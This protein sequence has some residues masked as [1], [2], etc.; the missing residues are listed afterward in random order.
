MGRIGLSSPIKHWIFLALPFAPS[1]TLTNYLIGIA[2]PRRDHL[3][4]VVY[5]GAD[6]DQ[7]GITEYAF[8][9]LY[10]TCE[11]HSPAMFGDRLLL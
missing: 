2:T 4:R 8:D 5:P 6:L 7:G 10:L 3:G 1:I 9:I 11:P